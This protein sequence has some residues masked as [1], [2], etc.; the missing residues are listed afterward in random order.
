MY[1]YDDNKITAGMAVHD[2]IEYRHRS[3]AP[4]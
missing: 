3:S 4:M 2:N 1:E